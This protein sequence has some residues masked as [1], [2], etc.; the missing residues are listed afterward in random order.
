LEKKNG[1]VKHSV[2]LKDGGAADFDAAEDFFGLSG[3][4]SKQ[5]FAPGYYAPWT[6][7]ILHGSATAKQVA[8]GIRLFIKWDEKRVVA[9]I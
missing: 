8:R 9:A 7:S 6:E 5:L 1:V 4:E 2:Y 3:F